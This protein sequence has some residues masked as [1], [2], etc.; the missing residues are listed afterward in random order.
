MEVKRRLEICTHQTL[1]LSL[2]LGS[3]AVQRQPYGVL[4]FRVFD[5]CARTRRPTN[6]RAH[7]FVVV[8]VVAVVESRRRSGH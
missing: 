7:L 5:T 8:V 1:S 3:S 6:A 4:E 2:F